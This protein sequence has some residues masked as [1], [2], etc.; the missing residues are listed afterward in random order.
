M[1]QLVF[2]VYQTTNF[3]APRSQWSVVTNVTTTSCV[4]PVVDGPHFFTVSVS[5][6]VTG[7][8]TFMN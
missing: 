5:N 1:D 6:T 7:L 8:E 2:N 4:L 3:M